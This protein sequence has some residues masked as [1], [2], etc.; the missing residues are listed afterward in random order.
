MESCP[1]IKKNITEKPFLE[2]NK[3]MKFTSKVME[4]EAIILSKE[5]KPQKRYI[6]CFLPF[7]DTSFDSSD[8]CVSFGICTE[9]RKL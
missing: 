1:P 2:E 6:M 3:T 8:M 7:V 4:F 9:A 5:L